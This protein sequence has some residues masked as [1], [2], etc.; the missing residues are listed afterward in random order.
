MNLSESYKNRL[1]ELAGI[2][3]N[4]DDSYSALSQFS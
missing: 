2:K 4:D 1:I 3:S